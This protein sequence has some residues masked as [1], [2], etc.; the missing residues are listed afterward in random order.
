[1]PIN[2]VPKILKLG[3]RV[4]LV[5]PISYGITEEMRKRAWKKGC[6]IYNDYSLEKSNRNIF[7]Y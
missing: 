2:K 3:K 7:Y 5:D 6:V 1:M 4:K